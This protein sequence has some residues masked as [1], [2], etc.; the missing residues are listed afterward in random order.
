MMVITE[1]FKHA[2]IEEIQSDADF[3]FRLF[4][5]IM[6]SSGDQLVT[7]TYLD[8]ALARQSKEFDEKLARQSKDF[9][10]KLTRALV[11]LT[12]EFDEKLT[13]LAE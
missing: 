5:A 10:E 7:K 1:E 12:K 4:K 2:I 6:V 13:R 11:R 8:N 9:D 3:G